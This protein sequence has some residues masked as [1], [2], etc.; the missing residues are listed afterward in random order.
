MSRS[1]NIK[2]GFYANEDLAECSIW[3]RF[4]FPGLWMMADRGGRLEY[5]PKK[6]KGELLRFDSVDVEPLLDDL[7][8]HGFI[9]I[10]TAGSRQY[11][12][13]PTFSRH[14]NPHYKEAGSVIPSSSSAA[15][16]EADPSNN[17]QSTDQKPDV[18]SPI[19]DQAS[20]DDRSSIAHQSRGKTESEPSINGQSSLDDSAMN[21]GKPG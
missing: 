15:K 2:P 3:A 20:S 18:S 12:E 10:Y 6:I 9:V 5:R 1:R 14:Q 11:I 21:G 19:I 7:A 17:G 4:I 13:I 8:A 16:P